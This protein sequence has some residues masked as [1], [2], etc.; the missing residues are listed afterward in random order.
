F[1][2]GFHWEDIQ[3]FRAQRAKEQAGYWDTTNNPE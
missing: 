1:V 3:Q 2:G